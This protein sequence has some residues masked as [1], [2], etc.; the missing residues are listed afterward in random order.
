MP[1]S[2]V[3]VA[4]AFPDRLAQLTA[5]TVRTATVPQITPIRTLWVPSPVH[6]STPR[7]TNSVT[8]MSTTMDHSTVA[9]NFGEYPF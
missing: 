6:Q 7:L 8:T 1:R 5:W 3:F 4:G 2:L 9:S